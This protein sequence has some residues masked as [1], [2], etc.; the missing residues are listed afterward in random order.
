MWML[1]LR[2]S[3]AIIFTALYVRFSSP[4]SLNRPARVFFAHSAA[5]PGLIFPLSEPMVKKD[6]ELSKEVS[7]NPKTHQVLLFSYS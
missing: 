7:Q 2:P 5:F 6:S 4:S 3:L 1:I